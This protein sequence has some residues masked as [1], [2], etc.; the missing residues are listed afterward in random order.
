MS[1]FSSLTQQLEA[2]AYQVPLPTFTFAGAMIEEIIAPIPSPIVMTL[3]GSIA[4]SQNQTVVFLASLAFIGA[5]GK[6]LGSWVV[7]FIADKAEDIFVRRFG[8]FFEIKP[9]DIE[10]IGKVLNH[11]W[12]D[13]FIITLMRAIPVFP[14]APVSIV[15]GLIKIN[16]KTYIVGTFLGTLIRNVFYLYLGFSGL[17]SLQSG[18]DSLESLMQL[19]LFA[20]FILA[21]FYFYH[22][23]KKKNPFEQFKSYLKSLFK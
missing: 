14:T 1:L 8:K 21:F 15:C 3:A 20:L 17:Q 13:Y 23:R 16:L 2:W 6:T 4:A 5:I 10:A 9:D 11:N 22:Q 18:L 12:K 7:Y 19:V